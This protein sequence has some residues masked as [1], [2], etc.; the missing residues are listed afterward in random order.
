MSIF[1]DYASFKTFLSTAVR[2]SNLNT[3][4]YNCGLVYLDQPTAVRKKDRGYNVFVRIT[5]SF[6]DDCRVCHRWVLDF[7]AG[8]SSTYGIASQENNLKY[9]D[10][11]QLYD[12][13]NN[14]IV[15]D[16]K[17]KIV[18]AYVTEDEKEI[19]TGVFDYDIKQATLEDGNDEDEEETKNVKQKFPFS[20]DEDQE[21]EDEEF[22]FDEE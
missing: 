20:I 3:L 15:H 19:I 18:R 2:T 4:Y 5:Y 17:I 8:T 11:S 22:D 21:V 9:I 12:R 7:T 16:Y 1:I 14:Q 10:I 13:V 6:L